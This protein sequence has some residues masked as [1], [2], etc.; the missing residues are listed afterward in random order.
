MNSSFHSTFPLRPK[1]C[2]FYGEFHD[3]QPTGWSPADKDRIK[4]DLSK[5]GFGVIDWVGE[6]RKY[7]DIEKMNPNK[8]SLSAL[9]NCSPFYVFC[10][11][12]ETAVVLF[13]TFVGRKL[14]IPEKWLIEVF[15]VSRLDDTG[16][17]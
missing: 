5:T 8:V 7:G 2:R 11:L 17:F 15:I 10:L 16:F 9:K 6:R 3:W 4:V 14:C 1:S 13:C 12:G